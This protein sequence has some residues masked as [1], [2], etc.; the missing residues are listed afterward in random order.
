MT[1]PSDITKEDLETSYNNIIKRYTEDFILADKWA[2]KTNLYMEKIL[3]SKDIDELIKI[4]K[5]VYKK[6]G[7]KYLESMNCTLIL[8]SDKKLWIDTDRLIWI[9]PKQ[10]AYYVIRN[11]KLEIY[12]WLPSLRL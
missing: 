12:D 9:T 5:D 2:R 3:R 4:I 8:M 10:N 7:F 1:K 11:E 6:T